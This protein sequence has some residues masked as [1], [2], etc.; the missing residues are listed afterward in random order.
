MPNTSPGFANATQPITADTVIH[1][2]DDGLITGDVV[3][4]TDIGPISGYRSVPASPGPHPVILVVHEIFGVHEHIRDITRRLAHEGYLAVAP[5][6]YERV[7]NVESL[8]SIEQIRDVVSRVAD[9]RVLADLDATVA[10]AVEHDG[11]PDRVAITGFCWGGRIVWLYVAHQPAL[12]AGVA[13]YGRLVNEA[14][15]LHPEHPVD[16]VDKLQAPVLGLY[17][18][19]DAGIPVETVKQ[20]QD[21]L[22]K[23]GD[24]SRIHL[25]PEAPHAFYADYRPSYRETEARDG[26]GRLHDWLRHYLRF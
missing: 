21:A 24:E 12:K 11:D 20:M 7:G 26:W 9:S 2:N 8:Q 15:S 23:A 3:I 10:W 6:L 14:T 17:G 18:G 1:T 5:N 4:Q 22:A 13:W 25:Y 19:A 16:V